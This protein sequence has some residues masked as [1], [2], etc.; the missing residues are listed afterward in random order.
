MRVIFVTS[1]TPA[2]ENIRGISAHPYYLIKFRPDAVDLVILTFND[3][4]M[5][6]E[7]V[8]NLK[9]DL[10][11]DIRIVKKDRQKS[12][13]S[14]LLRLPGH[15]I[16]VTSE[17]KEVIISY[18]PDII[19]T[20]PNY[21]SHWAQTIPERKFVNSAPDSLSLAWIREFNDK[22]YKRSL[23]HNVYRLFYWLRYLYTEKEETVSNQIVHFVGKE[24]LY[25]YKKSFKTDN[26][27]YLDHPHYE[28]RDKEIKFSAPKLQILI[29]GNNNHFM[30]V[31]IDDMTE[32]LVNNQEMTNYIEFTFLGKGWDNIAVLLKQS[33][34][35]CHIVTWVDHYVDE[36]IKYD[37]QLIP[38]SFGT[39][40]KAKVLDAMCNGVLAIGTPLAMENI[41]Y[42]NGESA[43][44]YHFANE[45]PELF[46][47]IYNHREKYE[48][49]AR[50]GR[51]MGRFYH[52]PSVVSDSFFTKVKEFIQG[53]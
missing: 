46:Q 26:G 48:D 3:N 21:F 8:E 13:K 52:N 41:H 9:K 45:L 44:C 20:Y 49:I 2:K 25:Q 39:G 1:V 12:I 38:I 42:V 7:Y 5:S 29:A 17:I 43:I 33:G 50:N 31:G 19:W 34:Y 22:F 36:V 4:G 53:E 10:N 27:F 37:I 28:L 14:F 16:K 15:D 47:D 51:E 11:C 30:R 23:L 35:R 40:T 32:V 24:D 18:N 6:Q